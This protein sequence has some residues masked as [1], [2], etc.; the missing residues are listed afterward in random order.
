MSKKQAMDEFRRRTEPM[1]DN[2]VIDRIKESLTFHA[3][4]DRRE[5]DF[6]HIDLI[7]GHT[8]VTTIVVDEN[9][10]QIFPNHE[11]EE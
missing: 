8:Y 7:I 9:N 1:L 4:R 3:R 2:F 5:P 10:V 11:E 6:L